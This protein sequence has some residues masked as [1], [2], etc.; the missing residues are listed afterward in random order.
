[1]PNATTTI[2]ATTDETTTAEMDA[3]R[4]KGDHRPHR[5]PANSSR[6]AHGASARTSRYIA[7]ENVKYG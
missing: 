2:T 6:R 5:R 3:S 4:A 7:D 1:V